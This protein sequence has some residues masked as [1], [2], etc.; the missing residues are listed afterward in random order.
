M[1]GGEKKGKLSK[2]EKSHI[3]KREKASMKT[4]ECDGE[5]EDRDTGTKKSSGWG[6]IWRRNEN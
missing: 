3:E 1:S 6:Q 4:R 5:V 2:K